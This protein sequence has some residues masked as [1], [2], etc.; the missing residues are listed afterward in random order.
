MSNNDYL[1]NTGYIYPHKN[2]TSITKLPWWKGTQSSLDVLNNITIYIYYI[3]MLF[4]IVPGSTPDLVDCYGM[5]RARAMKIV[6]IMMR[7]ANEV[8]KKGPGKDPWRILETI[9]ANHH[10]CWQIWMNNDEQTDPRHV[11]FNTVLKPLNKIYYKKIGQWWGYLYKWKTTRVSG[12]FPHSFGDG[13]W[14]SSSQKTLASGWN[15]KPVWLGNRNWDEHM[16]P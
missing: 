15:H 16:W 5:P 3:F 13:S 8:S 1:Y 14:G 4:H 9:T 7:I 11:H 10:H 6:L 2:L 12:G